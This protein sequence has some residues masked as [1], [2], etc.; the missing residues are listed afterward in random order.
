M[1]QITGWVLIGFFV[2]V[3]PKLALAVGC[4]AVWVATV[5]VILTW[6]REEEA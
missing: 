1:K 2:G 4:L 3:A 5:A 6:P